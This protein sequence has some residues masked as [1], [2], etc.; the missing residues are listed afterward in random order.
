MSL[1]DVNGAYGLGVM[2]ILGNLVS[3]K[4]SQYFRKFLIDNLKLNGQII[5]LT[6]LMITSLIMMSQMNVVLVVCG[7]MSLC[8]FKSLYRP[9]ISGEQTIRVV[10]NRLK[11]T[12]LSYA[13][14]LDAIFAS[15]AHIVMS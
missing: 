15:L 1:L 5:F 11:A 6:I 13:N 14:L 3:Y 9:I 4:G 2:Y 12:I 8:L 7:F 10:L